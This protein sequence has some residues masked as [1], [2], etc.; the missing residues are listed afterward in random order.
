MAFF[1]YRA[2]FVCRLIERNDALFRV[3]EFSLTL[4]A[5]EAARTN[6]DLLGLKTGSGARYICIYRV[7]SI[8]R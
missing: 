4:R 5:F 7:L 2:K 6:I 8:H 1:A 3:L